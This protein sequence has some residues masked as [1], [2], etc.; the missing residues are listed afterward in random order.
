MGRV[1]GRGRGEHRISVA[2]ANIACSLDRHTFVTAQDRLPFDGRHIGSI[3]GVCGIVRVVA[4]LHKPTYMLMHSATVFEI[5]HSPHP[6]LTYLINLRHSAVACGIIHRGRRRLR[7][8]VGS[9][10]ARIF[11]GWSDDDI[12]AAHNAAHLE[13]ICISK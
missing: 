7:P 3:A 1:N 13:F 5:V 2:R 9:Q 10:S 12:P 8:T 4:L 6:D 11:T